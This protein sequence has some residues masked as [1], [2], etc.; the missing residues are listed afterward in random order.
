MGNFLM[1]CYSK[2]D[3]T[4][5]FGGQCSTK[6]VCN[7]L[8]PNEKILNATVVTTYVSYVHILADNSKRSAKISMK[9]FC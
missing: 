7:A 1:E 8:H 9:L 3:S 6:L 5:I 4:L 2:E